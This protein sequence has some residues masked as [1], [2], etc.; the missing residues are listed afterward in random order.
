MTG[1]RGRLGGFLGVPLL[2][3]LAP[4]LIL[5]ILARI[6]GVGG[7]ANISAAQA[8]G[9]L[10]TVA[11]TFGWQTVGPVHVASATDDA[12]RRG[13]YAGSLR[14]RGLA[15][16]VVTPIATGI[17]ALVVHGDYVGESLLLTVATCALGFSPAWYCIGIGRPGMLILA[18]TIPRLAATGIAAVFVVGWGA[19]WVYPALL[20]IAAIVGPVIFSARLLGRHRE[21]LPYSMRE[22]FSLTLA[23]AGIDAAGN[24]YGSTPVP[25]AAA[26]LE[27]AQA[28][29]FTSA[30]R[31]YRIGLVVVVITLGNAFQGWVLDPSAEDPRRRQ[32]AAI[33]AHV[34]AGAVGA[35]ILGAAG[36]LATAIVFGAEVKAGYAVSIFYGIAFFFISVSTPLIRNLLLPSGRARLVFGATVISSAAGLAVML[37][38]AVLRSPVAIAG[39]SAL[40]ELVLVAVLALPALRRIPAAT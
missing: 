4:F 23:S 11:V 13:L 36:P 33:L 15:F 14:T 21:R 2:G 29:S 22:L 31:A 27:P 5:P 9:I 25:I 30:D 1:I 18:D 12:T 39:G 28:A 7:W 26:A 35:I 37:T 32:W 20:L 16:L 17:T 38:G 6:T 10:G 8:I 19:V 34:A 40:A 3:V 24:S